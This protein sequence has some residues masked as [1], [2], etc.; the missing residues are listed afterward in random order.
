MVII[1]I[2][3]SLTLTETTCYNPQLYRDEAG[4]I[5]PGFITLCLADFLPHQLTVGVPGIDRE[6]T[7]PNNVLKKA[8]DTA[9]ASLTA[10]ISGCKTEIPLAGMVVETDSS[11]GSPPN[12]I[13]SSDELVWERWKALDEQRAEE[14]DTSYEYTE[15]E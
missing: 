9:E 12:E 11:S 15:N 3:P 7:I 5:V 4:L 10:T 6:I 8:L 2:H 1:H 14:Q 13:S